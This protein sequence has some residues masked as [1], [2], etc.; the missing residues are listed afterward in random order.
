M[1]LNEKEEVDYF[2]GK[3]FSDNWTI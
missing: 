1:S 3:V 2:N